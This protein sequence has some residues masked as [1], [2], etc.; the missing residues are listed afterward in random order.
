MTHRA[1]ILF[2]P[3]TTPSSKSPI[4]GVLRSLYHSLVQN[5]PAHAEARPVGKIGAHRR[6]L[7]LKSN[8]SKR[9]SI[10]LAQFDSELTEC[11]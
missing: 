11:L 8:T 6:M 1:C 10:D 3:A 7:I 5:F 4:T 9:T 2:P